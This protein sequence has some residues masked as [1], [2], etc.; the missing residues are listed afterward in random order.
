MV[1]HRVFDFHR[2]PALEFFPGEWKTLL[3]LW[4][5]LALCLLL[6][7]MVGHS[8]GIAGAW[9]GPWE[10]SNGQSGNAKLTLYEDGN[11]V[12]GDWD[13]TALEGW[14]KGSELTFHIHDALGDCVNYEGRIVFY[15][16]SARLS[17]DADNHCKQA[18]YSGWQRLHR[19]DTDEGG[20]YGGSVQGAWR[21]H[22]ENSLGDRGDGSWT[23]REEFSNG[24]VRGD[25]DG[26]AF[27]GQRSG[28]TISFHIHRGQGGCTN[29][30]VNVTIFGRGD[31]ARLVYEAHNKCTNARYSGS[32][33]MHR[34]N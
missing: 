14:R 3:L 9:T 19:L 24:V 28:N 12:R 29:Y 20:S 27:E 13:G 26:D 33:R 11:H 2:R 31:A 15:G 1:H 4:L 5:V 7:P 8:Q 16:D 21:G 30:E 25:W 18:R 34:A 10:N 32:E 6:L 23:V 17:Y 22:W